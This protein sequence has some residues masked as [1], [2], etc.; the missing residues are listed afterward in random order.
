MGLPGVLYF[1]IF[2]YLPM[3]GIVIAF[4]DYNV[5]DGIF[6]SKF[7]GFNNFEFLIKSR[8]IYRITFNTLFL[9][10]LFILFGTLFQVGIALLLNEVY[11]KWFKKIAQSALLLPFFIS[12]VVVGVFVYYIFATDTGLMNGILTGIGL[13]PID[14]YTH[15]Q[16]WPTIL[17]ITYI[18]KWAGYGSIIYLAA[19]VGIDQQMYESALIDGCSKWQLIRYITLPSIMPTIM[20]LTL[21][22]IGRIFYGDFGMIFNIVK[23]NVILFGTTD[24][25][26]TYVYRSFQGSGGGIGSIGMGSAAGALQSFLGF[27]TILIANAAVRKYNQDYALY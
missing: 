19:I 15:S 18:W 25:I 27:I 11:A 24:V 2:S 16:Y 12:W 7:I 1:M 26:D 8:D 10:A 13:H 3:V 22:A 21:L 4:K 5:I 23:N 17:T 6:G 9:N 20:I 14:W